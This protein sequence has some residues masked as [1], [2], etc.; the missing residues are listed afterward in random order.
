M[1]RYDVVIAGI[2]GQGV[3]TL[4]TLLKL[5]A[6][7]QGVDVT[8]A[9]RRGGAQREGPVTSN[10]RY[11]VLEDGE[12]ADPR[13]RPFSGLIPRGG[14][15]LVIALEPLEAVRCL[16]YMNPHTV[17]ITE[18]A[19]RVPTAVRLGR[20]VYPPLER[21]WERIREVTPRLHPV[22]LEALSKER[23]GS[24][25][26]VNVIAL[27]LASALGDLPVTDGSLL[28]TV[29]ERLPGFDLNREA[30]ALGR[31]QAEAA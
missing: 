31:T 18:T 13:K 7:R 2:G 28:E 29:R 25:R 23:F 24:L 26:Q 11:R 15:H 12:R 6:I 5:A 10:V 3:I 20:A 21:L 14:A 8:G 1:K 16:P 27:G 19:P 17:V 4:G 22:P 30:F 9:E